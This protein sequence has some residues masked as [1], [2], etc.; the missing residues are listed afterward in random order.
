MKLLLTSD[1][2]TSKALINEFKKLATKPLRELRVLMVSA[3]PNT[4]KVLGYVEVFKK[5]L[6]S[7][8]IP[9]NNIKTLLLSEPDNTNLQ[10][11]DVLF[12]CG[13]N[14]YQYLHMIRKHHLDNK[15]KEFAKKGIYIG[16]SAGSIIAGPS[17]KSAADE[18]NTPL[19]DLTGLKLVKFTIIPHMNKKDENKI[20]KDIRKAKLDYDYYL[21]KDGEAV[22]ATDK[23]T[24][25][26]TKN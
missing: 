5:P 24:R 1:G 26:I 2:L 18:N 11:Y 19:K 16:V 17:I 23:E 13:G 7:A 15:I 21:I 20:K 9:I 4:S 25:I 8:G 10:D 14:T 6:I 3:G 22:L 12:V